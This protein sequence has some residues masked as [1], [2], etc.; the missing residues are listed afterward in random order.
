[1][2]EIDDLKLN[3]SHFI[4]KNSNK[5]LK[6]FDFMGY[7]QRKDINHGFAQPVDSRFELPSNVCPLTLTKHKYTPHVDLGKFAGRVFF[8]DK[9]QDY[10]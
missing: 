1:L 4:G 5:K 3:A 2:P 10:P 9:I 6:A 7:A 8:T